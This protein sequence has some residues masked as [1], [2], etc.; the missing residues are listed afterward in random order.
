MVHSTLTGAMATVADVDGMTFGYEDALF[1]VTAGAGGESWLYVVED[2]DTGSVT[3]LGS[4]GLTD[5]RALAFDWRSG[6]L[7]ALD[8]GVDLYEVEV[9]YASGAPALGAVTSFCAGCGTDPSQ[10]ALD[11]ESFAPCEQVG[12]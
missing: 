3:T 1:F 9:I 8:A 2:I 6:N 7:Y 5:V 11:C 12:E 4:T 10:D